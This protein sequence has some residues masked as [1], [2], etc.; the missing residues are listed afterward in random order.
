MTSAAAAR[1]AL[2]G[3]LAVAFTGCSFEQKPTG[4]HPATTADQV[5]VFQKTPN[6]Y[7]KL[8]EVTF[9]IPAGYKWDSHGDANLVF[10]G[11]KAEAAKRGATGIVMTD[12]HAPADSAEVGAGYKG[13]YFQIPV[14]RTPART[15]VAQAIYVVKE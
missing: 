10:D 1:R 3:V 15:A 4:P 8:G 6:K 14:R 12:E 7:E 9:A 5:K 2:I 13:E 11:L